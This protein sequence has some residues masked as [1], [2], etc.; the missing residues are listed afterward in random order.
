MAEERRRRRKKKNNFVPFIIEGVVALVVL[1]IVVKTATFSFNF[2]KDF[3]GEKESVKSG[4][5]V[6]LTIPAG[7][8]TEAIANILEEKELI[9]NALVFRILSRINKTHNSDKCRNY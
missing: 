9:D 4:E 5:Y 6:E 3:F 2:A 7:A 1:L 8:S